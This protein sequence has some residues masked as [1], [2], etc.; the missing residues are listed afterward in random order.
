MTPVREG[1]NDQAIEI[2]N[3][4]FHRLAV[5][6]W[7][8]GKFGL[9]VAGLDRREDWKIVDLF[10]VIGD[11]VDQLVAETTKVV[12]IHITQLGR[13]IGFGAVH[14]HNLT[15]AATKGTKSTKGTKGTKQI[16]SG[17]LNMTQQYFD[18]P[19]SVIAF[20][21]FVPFVLFCGSLYF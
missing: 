2:S 1:R 21:L 13:Q 16:T 5:S 14:G 4:I 17:T 12:G 8:R 3:N 6:R 10:E 19:T 11:P 20:V 15:Q 7:R 9:Q 18:P